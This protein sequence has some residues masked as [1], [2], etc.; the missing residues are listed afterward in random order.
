MRAWTPPSIVLAPQS[1]EANPATVVPH[2]TG[3]AE[4][5]AGTITISDEGLAC[6]KATCNYVFDTYG[7]FPA[8]SDA[9]HLMRF[10]QAH[11]I[12]ADFYDRFFAPGAYGLM[13]TSHMAT[14][15]QEIG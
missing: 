12:D 8:A 7:R 3:E 15:H 14:W 9:M 13:H 5:R 1:P 6:T 11:H 10:V 4:H 2:L